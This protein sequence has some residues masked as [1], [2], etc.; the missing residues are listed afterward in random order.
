MRD[1]LYAILTAPGRTAARI[2][3]LTEQIYTLMWSTVP[4]AI[5]YDVPKVQTS[6]E[7]RMAETFATVS[8]LQNEL[9]YSCQRKRREEDTIRRILAGCVDLDPIE[10]RILRYRY[11]DREPW[12]KIAVWTDVTD[13][14]IYQIH[15]SACKKLEAFLWPEGNKMQT[16]N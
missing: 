3:D 11:L 4:G 7:D 15:R 9:L 14:R 1:E 8:E 5:R 16:Q 12:T 10:R 13:R 2:Q 6:P